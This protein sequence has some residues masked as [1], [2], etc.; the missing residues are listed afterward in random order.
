MLFPG[1]PNPSREQ[2][3]AAQVDLTEP[4]ISTDNGTITMAPSK[5]GTV[6]MLSP[7]SFTTE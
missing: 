4:M 6:A 2:A 1:L 3:V 7:F 5:H